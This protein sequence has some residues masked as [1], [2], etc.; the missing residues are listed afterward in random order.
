MALMGTY[1][2][3]GTDEPRDRVAAAVPAALG[4]ATDGPETEWT[5]DGCLVTLGVDDLRHDDYEDPRAQDVSYEVI[6]HGPAHDSVAR[7]VYDAVAAATPWTVVLTAD[8]GETVVEAR[9]AK[10]AAA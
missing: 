1:V 8:E 5:V 9:P 6:V 2:L 4:L 3:L 7:Q 10:A